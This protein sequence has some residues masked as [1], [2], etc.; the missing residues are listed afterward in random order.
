[1]DRA[2]FIESKTAVGRWAEGVVACF[3]RA[4]GYGVISRNL[5]VGHLECDLIVRRGQ[6][7]RLCE[8]RSIRMERAGSQPRVSR[9]LGAA[10]RRH[11]LQAARR[12][13]QQLPREVSA[14]D[15]AFVFTDRGR[16]RVRV[17]YFWGVS[18]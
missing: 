2:A 5:R 13:N 17:D 9:I 1:M 10:K 11:L 16:E 14:I 12:L 15:I 4:R 8:V 3:L 7:T 6:E 18:L